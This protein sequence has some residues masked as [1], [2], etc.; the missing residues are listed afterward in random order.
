MSDTNRILHLSP[1]Y[2]PVEQMDFRH[3]YR[4]HGTYYL[5]FPA[6]TQPRLKNLT[7]TTGGLHPEI[8][9]AEATL[10]GREL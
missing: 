5:G 2:D 10:E 3:I 4:A 8:D 1:C 9:G 6:H 7:L